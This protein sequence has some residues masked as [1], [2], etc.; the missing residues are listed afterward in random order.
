MS[1]ESESMNVQAE[2]SIPA[3]SAPSTSTA[4]TTPAPSDG[5]PELR[6][7][8]KYVDSRYKD[9]DGWDY[10]DTE[11]A[12]DVPAELVEPLGMETSDDSWDEYCFVVVRKFP[13]PNRLASK[14]DFVFQVVVK[15]PYL[16]KALKDIIG[17]VP[18]ISW[19]AEPLEVCP[20]LRPCHSPVLTRARFSLT[21]IS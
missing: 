16:L 15:S 12:G 6:L 13:D 21:R 20:Y 3:S 7:D 19:T 10:N 2:G 14:D 17:Q 9:P 11:N 18:G 4:P 8:V 5:L 1:V